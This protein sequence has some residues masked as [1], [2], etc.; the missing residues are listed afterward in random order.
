MGRIELS[1][2]CRRAGFSLFQMAIGLLPALW[3]TGLVAGKPAL[4]AQPTEL[5]P[6]TSHSKLGV[7][8][9]APIDASEAHRYG[10]L[11]GLSDPQRQYVELSLQRY[12]TAAKGLLDR[13]HPALDQMSDDGGK[14][15]DAGRF[16]ESCR[17]G[18]QLAEDEQRVVLAL[19]LID[20]QFLAEIESILAEPQKSAIDRV[21]DRRTRAHC[22]LRDCAMGGA[23]VDLSAFVE[24]IGVTPEGLVAVDAILMEYER[25]LTPLFV[26]LHEMMLENRTIGRL[27]DA[28]TYL[29]S[30]EKTDRSRAQIQEVLARQRTRYREQAKLQLQIWEMNDEYCSRL[31]SRLQLPDADRLEESYRARVYKVVYPD[32]HD[33]EPVYLAIAASASLSPTAREAIESA[34]AQFARSYAATCLKMEKRYREWR[35]AF[36]STFMDAAFDAY[37]QDMRQLRDDRW[38]LSLQ[39]VKQL[40]S[41]LSSESRSKFSEQLTRLAADLE[42]A[43]A[44]GARDLYPRY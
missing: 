11:L 36:A 38:K 41:L 13:E 1:L 5:L 26:Q 22:Y 3:L 44:E 2:C 20:E 15:Q 24:I 14:A 32:N 21:R 39:F 40:D 37:R 29:L 43:R 18:A 16:E 23:H 8:L 27:D 35:E 7:R 6:P 28:E 25:I 9:P 33:P 34:H 42:A 17:I 19:R 10:D 30:T 12:Q 31:V 4:Q